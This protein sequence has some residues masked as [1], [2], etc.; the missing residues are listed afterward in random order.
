MIK[1]SFEDIQVGQRTTFGKTITEA[2]VFAF[3]GITGDFNPIHVNVEFA[4]TSMFG[5]RVAHGMLTA[6]LVDQTLTNLGGLGTIHL[7]ET[8]KFLAPVFIGDTV[9]VVS[10]VV[11]KDA[12]KT[13]MTVK[14]TITNQEGKT[15]LEGEA[16]IMM[17]REK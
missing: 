5:K 4:K 2:D 1:K 12:A 10:E 3:A 8:V 11:G 14:S 15:V 7:S 9:T 17:P 16:L 13:R 6:S